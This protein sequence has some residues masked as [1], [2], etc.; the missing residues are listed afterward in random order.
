[1]CVRGSWI[2]KL[3]WNVVIKNSE[4]LIH[5]TTWFTLFLFGVLLLFPSLFFETTFTRQETSAY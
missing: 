5:E 3:F 4:P 1:M 2:N